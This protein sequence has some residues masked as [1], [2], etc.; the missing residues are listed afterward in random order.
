MESMPLTPKDIV[1]IL[2]R[3]KWS[4]ILPALIIL[5]AGIGLAL[6]LPSIYQST[7]TV[8]IEEQDVPANF[9]MTTD[10]SYVE[11]RLQAINTR[12]MSYS[13]LL[14]IIGR[15]NLYP[16]YQDRWSMERIVAKMREDTKLEPVSTKVID[17]RTGRSTAATTAFTLSYEGKNPNSVLQ[18]ANVLVSLFLSENLR[19][20][21]KQAQETSDF[22]EAESEKIKGKLTD[23]D[24][25]IAVF[26]GDHINELPEVMQLNL[27]GLDGVER[28]IG[29][30]TEKLSNLKEKEEYYQTQLAGIDPY[31]KDT[32]EISSR[33]RLEELKVH[34]VHLTKRFSEEYP[35]VKK[36]RAE[37]AE[38]ENTLAEIAKTSKKKVEPPDNPA[39]INLAAQLAGVR[40]EITFTLH[41]VEAL[42]LSADEYHQRIAAAP[43]VEEAYNALIVD[44]N[45]TQAKYNDLIK[46]LM[47]AQ[48]AHG[49]EKDQKGER[50]T[51]IDPA[52]LPEKPYKPKR[53]AIMLIGL[54][55]G[56]GTGIGFATLR[57]FSDDAVRQADQLERATNF[58]VLAAIPPILTNKD[59]VRK[60]LKAIALAGG[61]LCVI[62]AGLAIFHFMVMDLYIFWAKLMR[63]L[64]I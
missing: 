23:L 45:N 1:D 36:T 4:L 11:Q 14:E 34:L 41:K 17:H 26:K 63:R 38:L 10:T 15:F 35:D 53:L 27:R 6:G 7:S 51:L 49:L 12:I 56:I 30:T 25:R 47:E 46:K 55:L 59:I 29:L 9:V 44:R 54:V 21:E 64:A 8:L 19:E 16:E 33:R 50:F 43:K 39:Y 37:I 2:K 42:N 40:I 57:E 52:R 3:R 22:L 58:P 5:S 62:V 18:V 61:T 31:T 28:D 20:R 24:A 32:A 48:V 13:S 60:R